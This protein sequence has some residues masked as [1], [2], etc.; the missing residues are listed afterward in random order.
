[1]DE[2]QQI[3]ARAPRQR[4]ERDLPRAR[5]DLEQDAVEA[6]ACDLRMAIEGYC[7]PTL[8]DDGAKRER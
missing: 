3:D 6:V 7:A 8:V 5:H 1:V 4:G 2:E